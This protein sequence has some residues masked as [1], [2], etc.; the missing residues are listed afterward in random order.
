MADEEQ[1]AILNQDVDAWNAWR[2]E[3]ANVV[4]DLC[5]ADLIGADIGKANLNDADL[6][7]AH[8]ERTNL[9]NAN[10][11]EANL[12]Q[13]DLNAANLSG[14]N[15]FGANLYQAKLGMANLSYAMLREAKLQA[16]DLNGADLLETNFV[17]ASLRNADLGRANLDMTDFRAVDLNGASLLAASLNMANLYGANLQEVGLGQMTFA[18]IDLTQTIGLDSCQ[19]SGPCGVDHRTLTRSKNVPIN[20]WRGCGVPEALIDYLPSLIDQAIQFYSCFISYSHADKW[21]A[22]RLHDQLQGQGIRCWLDEHQMLPGD[23]IYERVD[24]GIK[25][26]DKVLLCCSEAS[27]TSWW[28]DNEIDTAFEKERQFMKERGRKVLALIPP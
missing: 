28:V 14:A 7:W 6:S 12:A 20:F 25:L 23:D 27:L 18:N 13:A 15:L 11:M 1:L 19:H 24:E 26:W 9:H 10:L 21:F 5:G 22:R 8:L 4:P 17:E 16:A 2:D 3:N